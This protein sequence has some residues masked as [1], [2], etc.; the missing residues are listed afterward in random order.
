[1][2]L[3]WRDVLPSDEEISR[4][5]SWVLSAWG[6]DKQPPFEVL[7]N[8]RL[9]TAAGRAILEKDLRVELNPHLLAR[10]PEQ[11]LPTLVHE[12]A[13]IM[14]FHLYGRGPQAHGP[15]WQKLMRRAGQDP[16]ARHTMNVDG[17]RRKR[18]KFF[19]LHVCEG[20]KAG[21]IYRKV[22][23]D[24]ACRA[25]GPG[26]FLVLRAAAT[27]QGLALLRKKAIELK[28]GGGKKRGREMGDAEN[29]V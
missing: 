12:L 21:V 18:R 2:A 5:V 22:R 1:M 26:E 14:V 4:Q 27:T 6:L 24:I 3:D 29:E 23:R 13:H 15:E 25:C 28:S 8:F 16:Q 10:H 17:L 7:W 20:C 19:Y 11:F 9:R